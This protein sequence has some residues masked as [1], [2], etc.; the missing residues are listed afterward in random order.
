MVMYSYSENV[1]KLII[2]IIYLLFNRWRSYVVRKK[3]VEE[4]KKYI[5]KDYNEETKNVEYYNMK[6]RKYRHIK[7][8]TFGRVF[9]CEYRNKWYQ[10]HDNILSIYIF[11]ILLFIY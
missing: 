1:Y 11:I 10:R 5:F 8:M 9:D 2:I 7:P 6:T 3:V 4:M